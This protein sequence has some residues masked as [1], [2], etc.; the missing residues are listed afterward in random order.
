MFEHSR[1]Q[2]KVRSGFKLQ[3]AEPA[4]RLHNPQP[5][6]R[7]RPLSPFYDN[8]PESTITLWK[9]PPFTKSHRGNWIYKQSILLAIWKKKSFNNPGKKQSFLLVIHRWWFDR[10][11]GACAVDWLRSLDTI[12]D[13][14]WSSRDEKLQYYRS[15]NG[16]ENDYCLNFELSPIIIPLCSLR[17]I[18]Q[19]SNRINY[20]VTA[21]KSKISSKSRRMIKSSF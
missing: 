11:R 1:K 9:R 8:R 15:T 18:H 17:I 7:N 19:S 21:Y 6:H 13:F 14:R 12:C 5:R 10:N 4:P 20:P 3:P 16:T 2:G